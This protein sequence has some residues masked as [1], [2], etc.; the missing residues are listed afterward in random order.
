MYKRQIQE[1]GGGGL[2]CTDAAVEASHVHVS[3]VES[4][5][6]VEGRGCMYL[7]ECSSEGCTPYSVA[8]G[9]RLLCHACSPDDKS[10]PCQPVPE[11]P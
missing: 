3:N 6:A 5:F 9:G 8:D 7:S 4:A 1:C 2:V 10:L 11:E